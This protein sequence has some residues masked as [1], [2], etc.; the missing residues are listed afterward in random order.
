MVPL[1]ERLKEFM[2]YKR[3][4]IKEVADQLGYKS[5]QKLYRLF[6]TQNAWPSCQIIEDLAIKF[7]ELNINWLFTGRDAMLYT[8]PDTSDFREKYYT[9]LEEKAQ[10]ATKCL[11]LKEKYENLLIQTNK[12][13]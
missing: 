5:P 8:E 11:E 9:C 4:G 1:V 12:N 6:N 13:S 7:K 2:D 10:I 3:M